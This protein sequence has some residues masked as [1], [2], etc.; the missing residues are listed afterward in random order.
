MHRNRVHFRTSSIDGVP[1]GQQRQVII[2]V[3]YFQTW[4]ACKPSFW[5]ALVRIVTSQAVRQPRYA[6][7]LTGQYLANV[8]LA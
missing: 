1:L 8:L 7:T 4:L 2:V 6:N 5:A 3:P